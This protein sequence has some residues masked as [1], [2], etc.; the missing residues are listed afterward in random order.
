MRHRIGFVID[1]VDRSGSQPGWRMGDGVDMI[2]LIGFGD[3]DEG[4][5][6]GARRASRRRHVP[7]DRAARAGQEPSS[8][9]RS[10]S[11]TDPAPEAVCNPLQ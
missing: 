7:S 4:Y 5:A 6:R 1:N 3:G 2:A 10:I 9:F 8:F 11:V